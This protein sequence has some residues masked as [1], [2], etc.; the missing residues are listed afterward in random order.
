MILVSSAKV[1]SIN[2]AILTIESLEKLGISLHGILFNRVKDTEESKI[3]EKDNIEII[4]KHSPTKNHLIIL[5]NT[6]EIQEKKLNLFL[7]GEANG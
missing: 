7:K 3:Y 4:L 6:R 5:E 2:H 1:G